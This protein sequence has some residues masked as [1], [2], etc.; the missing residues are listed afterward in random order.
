MMVAQVHRTTAS[1]KGFVEDTGFQERHPLRR[2]RLIDLSWKWQAAQAAIAS[3]SEV[4]DRKIEVARRKYQAAPIARSATPAREI[5]SMMECWHDVAQGS[6]LSGDR[7]RAVTAARRDAIVAVMRNCRIA[8]RP[9]T[10]PELGR[11]F[12]RDVSTIQLALG[13]IKARRS[14]AK[15]GSHV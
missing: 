13:K 5:I 10:Y 2:R 7:T 8:G 14:L 12:G 3:R 11:V 4:I 1:A 15:R 9:F 6:I